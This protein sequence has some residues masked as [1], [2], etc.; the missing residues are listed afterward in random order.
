[1]CVAA[2]VC[3]RVFVCDFV[4]CVEFCVCL[5]AHARACERLHLCVGVC[6]RVCDPGWYL[7]PC[8]CIDVCVRVC[9]CVCVEAGVAPPPILTAPWPLAAPRP[10]AGLRCLRGPHSVPYSALLY[11]HVAMLVTCAENTLLST[12]I[13]KMIERTSGAALC[14]IYTVFGV[15]SGQRRPDDVQTDL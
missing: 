2:R 3:V 5:R 12:I 9:E 13:V 8:V 14:G 11:S 7:A 4:L 1:M 6:V 15:I 10:E